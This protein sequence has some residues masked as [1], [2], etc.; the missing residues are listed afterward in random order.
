MST[1][2]RLVVIGGGMAAHRL[3][4]ALVDRGERATPAAGWQVTLLAEEPRAPYDRV[5]LTSYF[6]GR[7]PEDLALGDPGLWQ[8]PGVELRRGEQVTAVDREARVVTTAGGRTYPYDALVLATGSSAFVPPVEGRDLPGC[9]VY[10]T[11]DDVAALRQWVEDARGRAAAARRPRPVVGAVVGGGLLGLEAAG[12]LTALGVET[13]VVEFAPRLMPLQVDEGGGEALKRLVGALDV[14]VHAGTATV[15][16][17]RRPGRARGA[18]GRRRRVGA[19]LEKLDVDV[20]VFAAGVRPRD[21]LAR[22]L[23]PAGGATRRGRRRRALPHRGL[24]DLGDRRGGVPRGAHVR[25]RG[26][27]QHDGRGG[28]RPAARRHRDVPRRRP[29]DEAQAARRRRRQ[30][31]RRVRDGRGRAV[32]RLRRPGGRRLQEAGAVGRR[33]HPARRRPRRRR[34]GVRG[35]AADGRAAAR[36]RP[37]GVAA[38]RGRGGRRR[39]GRPAGRRRRSARATRSARARCGTPSARAAARTSPRSRRAPGPGRAAAPACRW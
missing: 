5:A 32:G 6:S 17:D 4:A 11:I 26:A 12:A 24:A 1:G 37:G 21:E 2:P 22:G 31:R 23:R 33:P 27:G 34:V 16:A 8:V 18:D 29:V 25:A 9:F 3:V 13:H 19:G 10:R 30:L 14:R 35:A 36:R 20:V 7:D 39:L 28:R 15:A 38:A